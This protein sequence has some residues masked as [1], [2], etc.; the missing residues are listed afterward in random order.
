MKSSVLL[1]L[2]FNV[3]VNCNKV[4]NYQESY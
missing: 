2:H 4:L 3:L 1:L